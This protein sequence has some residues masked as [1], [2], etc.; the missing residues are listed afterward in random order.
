MKKGKP[1]GMEMNTIKT[2][3]MVISRKKSVPNFSISVEGEPIQQVDRMVY[4]GY[5]ATEDGKCDKEI[6]ENV[7]RDMHGKNIW[8]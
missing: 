6:R 8:K 4:L 1:Y 7:N 5:V 2:K 3:W